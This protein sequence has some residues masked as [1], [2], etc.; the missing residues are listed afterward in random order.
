MPRGE[1]E[2]DPGA[3]TTEVAPLAATMQEMAAQTQRLEA[4]MASAEK[5]RTELEEH[6][7]REA[8]GGFS[9]AVLARCERQCERE[10]E[11]RAPA[12]RWDEGGRSTADVASVGGAQLPEADAPVEARGAA[13]GLRPRGGLWHRGGVRTELEAEGEHVRRDVAL[14]RRRCRKSTCRHQLRQSTQRHLYGRRTWR[15]ECRKRAG[16]AGVEG[17]RAPA[18]GGKPAGEGREGGRGMSERG[19]VQKGGR[20]VRRED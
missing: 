5:A 8:L 15:R 1:P 10:A 3:K 19:D 11:R 6:V 18:K 2:P 13:E 9:N 7:R 17:G 12:G 20:R 16:S 14:W 4:R